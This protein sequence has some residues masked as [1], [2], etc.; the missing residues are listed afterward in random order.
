MGLLVIKKQE[1]ITDLQR[2]S[3][4][5]RQE[6]IAE[7]ESSSPVLEKA[8]LDKMSKKERREY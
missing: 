1:K 5:I 3:M 2:R 4:D 8:Q 7:D 6:V